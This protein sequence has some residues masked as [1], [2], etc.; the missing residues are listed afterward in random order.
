MHCGFLTKHQ[1]L[2]ASG[3]GLQVAEGLAHVYP[4]LAPTCEWDTAAAQIIVQEA[5]GFVAQAGLCDN[6]GNPLENWETVLAENRPVEYNKASL[7]NPFFVVYG[8][9][10][11]MHQSP[12]Q[13]EA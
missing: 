11:N 8:K 2:Q 9:R 1:S 13:S 4:R 5:G 7:L 3:I 12:V 6:A 10:S